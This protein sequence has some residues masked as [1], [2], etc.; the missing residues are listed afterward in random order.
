MIYLCILVAIIKVA[1]PHR[2]VAVGI[3]VTG[4]DRLRK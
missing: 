3:V 1:A 4:V 2:I